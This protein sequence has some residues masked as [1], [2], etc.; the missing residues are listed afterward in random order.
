MSVLASCM[1]DTAPHPQSLRSLNGAWK[2]VIASAKYSLNL[3]PGI[4]RPLVLELD[5]QWLLGRV[6]WELRHQN[7][8]NDK[9]RVY[10]LLSLV[11]TGNGLGMYVS[12]PFVP[13]YT[14]TVEWAYGQF[15]ARYGGCMS[16]FYAG[17]SRR[18]K[19]ASGYDSRIWSG[20]AAFLYDEN[21]LP[22][23]CPDLRPDQNA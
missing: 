22:S 14:R 8:K 11:S 7:C 2:L 3:W 5:Q 9:D 17:I 13:D 21:M 4:A 18:L 19:P 6:A 23:W 20:E 16:L 10:A 15:W 12:K 1:T